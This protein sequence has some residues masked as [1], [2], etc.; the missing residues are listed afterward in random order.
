MTIP[1][2]IEQLNR[3]PPEARISIDVQQPPSPLLPTR[4]QINIE[5]CVR[6]RLVPRL[7]DAP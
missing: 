2:L 3:L 6:V 4:I 5:A 7:P 1:E